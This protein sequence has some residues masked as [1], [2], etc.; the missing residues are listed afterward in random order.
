MDYDSLAKAVG[1]MMGSG[2]MIVMDET[3]CMV[4]VARYFMNFL[5][6]ES[7]GKCTS[8]RK[9]PADAG[10]PRRN[11]QRQ[12]NL[13]H[14]P[15]S[16]KN[17]DTMAAASLCGLGQVRRQ[18][19]RSTLRYFRHEYEAHIL[20]KKCPA[21]V[22]RPLLNTPLTPSPLHH[23]PA[24]AE[25]CPVN[26]ITCRQAGRKGHGG[27]PFLIG[28]RLHQVRHVLRRLP[29]QRRGEGLMPTV[30]FTING[31]QVSCE[32]LACS[33]RVARENGFDVPG[34]CYHEA[35]AIRLVPALPGADHAG[36][37]ELDRDLLPTSPCGGTASASRRTRSPCAATPAEPGAAPGPRAQLGG[38]AADGARA[39]HGAAACPVDG[40]DKC[41]LCGLPA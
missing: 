7:C 22:C 11:R 4:D 8:C 28:R 40:T 29:R 30:S 1:S 34:L 31:Q 17:C 9:A 6:D 16:W 3:T 14:L 13:S 2:G 39:G 10:D 5:R 37:V 18:P 38:P 36:Q 21:L 27:E 23:V 24:A 20:D 19:R 33:S 25:N 15:I 12:G 35:E 26:C 32:K 41:I